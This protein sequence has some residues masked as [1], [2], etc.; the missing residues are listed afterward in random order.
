MLVRG[1]PQLSVA[2]LAA[3][4]Y[5]VTGTGS[6]EAHARYLCT[7]INLYTERTATYLPLSAFAAP[8]ADVFAGKRT[9]HVFSRSSPETSKRGK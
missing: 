2:T 7:L 9:P 4:R 6:S 3:E 5:V 1:L 8:Q